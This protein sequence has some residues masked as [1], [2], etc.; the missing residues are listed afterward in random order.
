MR[1]LIIKLSAFGDIIH[2]LPVIDCFKEY[3]GKY[4]RDAELHWLVEKR[5]GPIL[6]NCPEVK[7]IILT[8][9]KT[10]RRSLF[11]GRTLQELSGFWSRLRQAKY[12]LVIDI[13]GLIRSALLSR[14]ARAELRVGF[15]RD[16]GFLREPQSAYLLDRTFSIPSG[17]VVDQTVGLLEKVLKIKVPGIIHP[18]LPPNPS[19]SGAAQDILHEKDIHSHPYAVIA[20]GGGWETKLL[21]TRSIAEFCDAVNQ[22]GIIPVLA[23]WGSFEADRAAR[24][25][26]TARCDVRELGNLPVDVFIEILRMSRIVIGPDTGAVHSASAVK[27]PTVSYY[28]PSSAGYSGPRRVT[29]KVAQISPPCGPCF[30]RKCDRGLCHHLDIREVLE[31]I[32]EQLGNKGAGPCANGNNGK[33]E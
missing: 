28:G 24:I 11:Y 17:H 22:H 1:V 31:G 4:N 32:H 21:H 14:L 15:S 26:K 5:W 19:R 13:N 23:W 9:T 30:K 29:D 2:S 18:C 6:G 12:D 8:D 3:A 7:N 16:S 25:M 20:A 10:W 27:T 33:L